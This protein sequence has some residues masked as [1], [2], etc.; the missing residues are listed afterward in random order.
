MQSVSPVFTEEEV[1]F[2]RE[3]AKNNPEYL[4][5]IGLPVTLQIV[6]RDD[7]TKTKSVPDWA[8]AIR[9]RLSDEERAAVAAGL[10][11]V[12]TQLTF[13]KKLA[14]MNLQLCLPATKPL[15]EMRD[16]P[17]MSAVEEIERG[18]DGFGEGNDP[19]GK[20]LQ[21][22]SLPSAA[23]LDAVAAEEEAANQT[24]QPAPAEDQPQSGV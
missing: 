8:I 11:L 9:F 3:I 6:D 12:V 18:G 2:E 14:P 23:D 24:E 20:V 4:A 15:F 13:G 21:M 5:V 16:E 10:D 22:P 7:P 19:S 1:Q 17:P